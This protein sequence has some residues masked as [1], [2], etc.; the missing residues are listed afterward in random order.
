MKYLDKINK[1]ADDFEPKLLKYAAEVDST[2]ITLMARPVI[3]NI[4]TAQAPKLM[5]SIVGPAL[6]KKGSGKVVLGGTF[7]LNAALKG[8]VWKIDPTTSK[9][10]SPPSG[11]ATLDAALGKTGAIL[12]AAMVKALETEFNKKK[13]LLVGDTITNHETDTNTQDMEI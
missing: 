11:D 10:V 5:M 7:F 1:L 3:N 13:D 6:Q 9:L 8:G 4:F 2:N 12:S